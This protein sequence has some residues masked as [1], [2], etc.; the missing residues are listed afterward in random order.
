MTYDEAKEFLRKYDYL[1][2]D[3]NICSG[4]P[5]TYWKRGNAITLDGEFT[6]EELEAIVI[7]MKG[8]K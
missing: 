4:V 2:P 5:Y 6:I 8:P 1:D 7:Y 3:G